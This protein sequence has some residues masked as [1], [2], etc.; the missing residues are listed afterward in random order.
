MSHL[1][2]FLNKGTNE[3]LFRPL[4]ADKLSGIHNIILLCEVTKSVNKKVI[5][6]HLKIAKPYNEQDRTQ[7][8]YKM[9][10]ALAVQLGEKLTMPCHKLAYFATIASVVI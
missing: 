4:I 8:K 9:G 3:S 5:C 6:I 10:K 1:L 2:L 7:T